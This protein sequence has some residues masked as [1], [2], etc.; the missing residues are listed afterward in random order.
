MINQF[1]S[2]RILSRVTSLLSWLTIFEIYQIPTLSKILC[3][4][5]FLMPL[6]SAVLFSDSILFLNSLT[7]VYFET[8]RISMLQC[9]S[10]SVCCFCSVIKI[11]FIYQ[12]ISLK[13]YIAS[14]CIK[15]SG[16][17]ISQFITTIRIFIFLCFTASI[18]F[19]QSRQRRFNSLENFCIISCT[20]SAFSKSTRKTPSLNIALSRFMK[21]RTALNTTDFLPT[22]SP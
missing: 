4:S 5:K 22:L 12:L 15:S 19:L 11:I 6:I 18:R 8:G 17:M 9:P 16:L 13:N 1:R 14:L 3:S 7:F 20:D 21:Y 2:F 10:I